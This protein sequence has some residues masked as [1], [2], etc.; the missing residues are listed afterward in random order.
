MAEVPDDL[1]K[2]ER[3]AEEERAKLAGLTGDEYDAQLRRWR[4]ASDA[5]QAAITAHAETTGASRFDVEQAVK[6]AVRHAQEDPAVE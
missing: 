5:V 2:L 6:K 3:S 1:I 4:E